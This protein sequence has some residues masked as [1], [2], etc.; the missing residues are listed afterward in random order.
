[1][2][3]YVIELKMIKSGS[4]KNV[5]N[6]GLTKY[7]VLMEIYKYIILKSLFLLKYKI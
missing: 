3:R 7:D 1:M 2:Y 5:E 4:W 6:A